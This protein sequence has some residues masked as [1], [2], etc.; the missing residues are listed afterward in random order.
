MTPIKHFLASLLRWS[1]ETARPSTDADGDE[2]NA[3]PFDFDWLQ[4]NEMPFWMDVLS[5][6]RCKRAVV[7][8]ESWAGGEIDSSGR[9]LG[10]EVNAKICAGDDV[11]FASSQ[12]YWRVV[13]LF[14]LN[15]VIEIY[16]RCPSASVHVGHTSS[17]RPAAIWSRERKIIQSS[18]EPT[19]SALEFKIKIWDS[20][21]S[22][23]FDKVNGAYH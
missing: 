21:S 10:G 9:G 1:I 20:Y 7:T 5:S 2:A 4:C 12:M 8:R 15:R 19:S 14:L 22:R 6:C 3:H 17:A 23:K 18:F 11:F 16:G 13:L